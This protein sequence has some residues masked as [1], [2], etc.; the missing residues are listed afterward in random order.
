MFLRAGTG[1]EGTKFWMSVLSDIRNRGVKNV[2][3]LICDELKAY[4]KKS[5]TFGL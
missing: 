4:L 3:F 1:G 5:G 2:F